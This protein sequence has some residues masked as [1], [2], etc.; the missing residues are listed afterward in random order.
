MTK[1]IM[2]IE[3]RETSHSHIMP[4]NS[5]I[6]DTKPKKTKSET[7]RLTKNGAVTMRITN[8]KVR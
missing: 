8:K 2:D 5:K 4:N 1:L 3:L 6:R 7:L